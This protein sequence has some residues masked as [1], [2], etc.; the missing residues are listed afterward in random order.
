MRAKK[1]KKAVVFA[2]SILI[3]LWFLIPVVL[4]TLSAFAVSEDYYNPR[5]IIPRHFTVSHFYKLFFTLGAGHSP[6]ESP[7]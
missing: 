1:L 7:A 6:Q 2:V 5:L 3:G 4:I